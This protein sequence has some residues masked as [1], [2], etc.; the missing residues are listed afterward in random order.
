MPFSL[1]DEVA[2]FPL[3]AI[4]FQ[5][6]LL[7]VAIAIEATVLRR[8]LRLGFQP[9]IRY[10]ATLNLLTVVVGWVVF[11]GLEPALPANARTQVISYVLFDHFYSNSMARGVGAAVV[12]AGLVT[13]F[14]AFWIKAKGLEWLTWI[15][16]VPIVKPVERTNPNRI[17]YGRSRPDQPTAPPHLLAVLRANALSFTA[18]LLLLL[19]RNRIGQGL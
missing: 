14:V 5:S 6:L 16:G 12:A 9:S 4:L 1:L 10:A 18:V 3:R 8:Q 2:V 15:L 19:L 11:L 7:L 13:F 17:R